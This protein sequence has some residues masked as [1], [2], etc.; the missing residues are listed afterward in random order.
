MF[1]STFIRVNV[2]F[3][4]KVSLKIQFRQCTNSYPPIN[5]NISNLPLYVYCDQEEENRKI[6]NTGKGVI[7]C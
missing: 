7:T 4:I 5:V 6:T 1:N 2:N 3:V